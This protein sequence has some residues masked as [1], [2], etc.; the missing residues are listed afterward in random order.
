MRTASKSAS[1]TIRV[2]APAPIAAGAAPSFR[3]VTINLH[4]GLS[5][6]NQRATV[7]SVRDR[8]RLLH[9]DLVFAQEVQEQHSGLRQRFAHWPDVDMSRFLAADFWPDRH[10]GRNAVY[11]HGHHGN[12]IL[13]RHP[14]TG[15]ANRDISAYRF[16]RRGLLHAE[17][18]LP[19]LT[20]PLH[21]FCVHLA[22]LERG[23]ALQLD[24]I[25]DS[26]EA[27]ATAGAPVILAGDFNDWRRR[28][29]RRLAAAGFTEV[30]EVL[31]GKPAATFPSHMPVLRLD[32]IY[33]RGLKVRSARVL[34]DWAGL[35]D[36]LGLWAELEA[37]A[38]AA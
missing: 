6:L 17:I 24:S 5:A 8:L 18:R 2:V 34:R 12:A 20:L 1:P 31:T 21:C 37:T 7:H 14:L 3:L 27:L 13:S 33:V 16:E 29:S 26:V 28:A 10:Y 30:F 25:L 15:G 4:K 35:S 11:A 9:P 32:R 19:R 22:L 36:H 38:D 23:R